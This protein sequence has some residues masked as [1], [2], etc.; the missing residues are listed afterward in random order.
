M[1][2]LAQLI[3]GSSIFKNLDDDESGVDEEKCM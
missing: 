1:S 2:I 3:K